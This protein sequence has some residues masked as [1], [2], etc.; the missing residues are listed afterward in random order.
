MEKERALTILHVSDMQFGRHHQFGSEPDAPPN[1]FDTLL[2]RIWD[3]IAGRQREESLKPDLLICTGDLAE[4]GWLKEFVDATTFLGALADRLDLKRDRVVIIPGN[5][6]IN[7]KDCLRSF[8]EFIEGGDSVVAPWYAKWKKYE[9]AFNDFYQGVPGAAFHPGQPWS[10]F[11]VPSL[12]VVVAG[13]NSTWIEGHDWPNDDSSLNH[14]K[15]QHPI[16]HAGWCGERQLRWF[17]EK[18]SGDEF[19]GWLKIGAIHHNIE[20]GVRKDNENLR[21]AEDLER[22]LGSHLHLVLHGH[23]HRAR[24]GRL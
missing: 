23:T 12:E 21:D 11:S 19:H 14:L 22:V 3:D 2:E 24:W 6:D 18:L 10:L 13:L 16:T 7:R 20:R 5:H 1:E 17:A 4:Y 15:D 9:K 8:E